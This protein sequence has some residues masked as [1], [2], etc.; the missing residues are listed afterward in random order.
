MG[1]N[2][3]LSEPLL[4]G[5]YSGIYE[6]QSQKQSSAAG[7]MVH[8]GAQSQCSPGIILT[9]SQNSAK[10]MGKVAEKRRD[11]SRLQ[12]APKMGYLPGRVQTLFDKEFR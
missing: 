7:G 2:A 10:I 6:L 9:C 4:P 8:D 1:S 3:L 12:N 11:E 5:I